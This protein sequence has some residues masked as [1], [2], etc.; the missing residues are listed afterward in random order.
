[1]PTNQHMKSLNEHI[2]LGPLTVLK[3]LM[4]GE[5]V[6]YVTDM[7]KVN[8]C[9]ESSVYKLYQA[10]ITFLNNK[11]KGVFSISQQKYFQGTSYFN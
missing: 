5:I 10:C 8:S 3:Y 7:L 2:K 9:L 4:V 1:M 11:Y 6:A